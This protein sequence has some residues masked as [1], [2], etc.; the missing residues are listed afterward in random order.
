MKK[1]NNST[2]THQICENFIA[3]VISGVGGSTTLPIEAGKK[4]RKKKGKKYGEV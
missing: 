4:R 1:K 2:I 3:L